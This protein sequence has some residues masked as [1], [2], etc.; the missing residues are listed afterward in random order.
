MGELADSGMLA[1]LAGSLQ[2]GIN[3][4]LD[5]IR[6]LTKA[7]GDPQ[8]SFRSVQVTGTNGKTSVARMAGAI[9][10]GQGVRS[11]VYT[12]PHLNSYTERLEIGGA[13]VSEAEL[14]DGLRV[15]FEAADAIARD[16]TEFEILTA[17]AFHLMRERGVECA[18]LEVGMGGRWDAT[19]VVEPRVSVITGVALDHTERLGSTREEIA[20]DKAHIIKTGSLAVLGPGCAGVEDIFIERARRVGVPVTRVSQD[21]GDQTWRIV[22]RPHRPNGLLV[23][24]VMGVR[25]LRDLR[26]HVPTYQ[27]P[28]IATAVTAA[29]TALWSLLDIPSVRKSLRSL[30]LPGRFETLRIDPPLVIDG[31]HNPDAASV[32]AGA[33]AE[34]F[35]R[36]YPTIVL[37]VLADKDV[38]G[39]VRALAPV[40]GG[41][42]ATQNASPRCLPAARLA[43]IVHGVTGT[44]P[45]AETDLAAAIKIASEGG[46]AAVVTGSL[47]TAGA[48]RALFV[49]VAS[50]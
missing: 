21:G 40:A 37:G 5:G 7:L 22:R 2:F 33:I 43:E 6:A 38:A 15:A 31:A 47:Y 10:G 25:E 39:I 29:G 35:E 16:F 13:P 45:I 27:A 49:P 41:F 48:A 34:A 50:A 24:D 44:M 26:M 23:I 12:S 17:A 30:R 4:S 11:A 28:N 3:P 46:R 1:R 36:A 14:T 9:I 42:V 32:L 19:S 20:A 18:V 8:R